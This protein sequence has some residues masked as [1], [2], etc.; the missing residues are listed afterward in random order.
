MTY[1]RGVGILTVD[2]PTTEADRELLDSLIDGLGSAMHHGAPTDEHDG[3]L[4]SAQ[5]D[6]DALYA[7][8]A[9]DITSE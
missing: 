7:H 9:E 1:G 4:S 5:P 3:V 2:E 6:D 8:A